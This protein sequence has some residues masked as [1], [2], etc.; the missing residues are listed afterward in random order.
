MWVN[1][2]LGASVQD[3]WKS[4]LIPKCQFSQHFSLLQ[5]VKSL[6]FYIR[7][8][9]KR[10]PFR[11][12]PPRTVHYS[13]CPPPPAARGSLA[14]RT[15]HLAILLLATDKKTLVLTS[16][17]W[18]NRTKTRQERKIGLPI[19]IPDIRNFK[20]YTPKRSV[21]CSWLISS[22]PVLSRKTINRFIGNSKLK[23]LKR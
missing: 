12:E 14:T 2:P 9:W 16:M 3:I 6:P 20:V 15:F 13:E 23:S 17:A 22:Q 1:Q 18:P 4:F 11:A 21:T 5:L 8:A 10:Y 19:A 7:P